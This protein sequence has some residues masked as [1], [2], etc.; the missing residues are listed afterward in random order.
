MYDFPDQLLRASINLGTM[1]DVAIILEVDPASIYSWIA[2]V[3]LPPKERVEAF[4]ARLQP[5]PLAEA[6]AS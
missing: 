6:Q 3:D 2:G 1:L 5:V 4:N